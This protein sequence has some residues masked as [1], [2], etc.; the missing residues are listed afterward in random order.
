MARD[1]LGR[2][3][4]CRACAAEY[5]GR[6]ARPAP[7]DPKPCPVCG[8]EVFYVTAGLFEGLAVEAEADPRGGLMLT[9]RPDGLVEAHTWGHTGVLDGHT[10]RR[11]HFMRCPELFDRLNG[12][13]S[14]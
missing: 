11:S 1:T 6:V 12:I 10:P 5:S 3:W 7:P 2:A 4:L 13:E 9:L 8:V 14:D